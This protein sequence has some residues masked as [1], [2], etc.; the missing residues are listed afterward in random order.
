MTSYIDQQGLTERF[1]ADELARLV[2]TDG[3]G[4]PD[5]GRL[6][7]AI[8]DA[9]SE[10]NTAIAENYG[11]PVSDCPVLT[12]IAADIVRERLY[13]DEVPDA[14][15]GRAKV[16]RK[17]LSDIASGNLRLLDSSNGLIDT[18]SAPA[19]ASAARMAAYSETELSQEL[20]YLT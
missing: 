6:Q 13:D 9:D 20:D 11:V 8:A 19:P 14:V 16:S 7:S 1:G 15:A 18:R 2:D 3:D 12:S 10:I 5:T 4:T 17:M